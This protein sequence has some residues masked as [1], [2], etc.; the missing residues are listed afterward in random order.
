MAK[1]LEEIISLQRE[2][3]LLCEVDID[4]IVG[5]KINALSEM[6][7]FKAVEEIV[8]LR[9]EFPS[10]L[11]V[12]AKNQGIEDPD[13]ILLE[14][15]DVLLF[16][17]NFTL[18]R[19]ISLQD[20]LE[21]IAFVQDVNFSKLKTKKLAILNDEISRVPGQRIGYGGGNVMPSLIFVGS[22][23]GESLQEHQS[24]WDDVPEKSAVAFLK[25]A[26][27]IGGVDLNEV[28]FTNVVKE[29]TENNAVPNQTQFKFWY[30]FFRREMD[31]ITSG[32]KAPIFS[33][34][35]EATRMLMQSDFDRGFI[36]IM[37]PGWYMRRGM[38]EQE[39]WDGELKK[40]L[41]L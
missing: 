4:T 16:L 15:S 35:A 39:Y 6:Y 12:W 10:E 22:N 33:L 18:A 40:Y 9:K 30:P 19:K 5:S 37:H 27:T 8:E 14:L 26:L 41:T 36:N 23:P 2:F 24:C 25:R 7:L 21:K 34:G 3:Q 38:T 17:I 13:G 31:T 28:Y 1:S 20:V 11:N 29:V 32:V